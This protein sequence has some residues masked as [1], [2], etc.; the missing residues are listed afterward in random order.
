MF[1]FANFSPLDITSWD[2][3]LTKF[4]RRVMQN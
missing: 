4:L 3:L 1:L 2:Q